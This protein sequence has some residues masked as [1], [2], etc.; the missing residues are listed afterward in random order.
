M[1]K[2]IEFEV[3]KDLKDIDT[4]IQIEELC[5]SGIPLSKEY[6]ELLLS[7]LSYMIRKKISDAEEINMIENT[8]TNK[9]DLAQSMTYYYLKELNVKVNPVN[10]NEV[11]EGVCGH[12]FVI[13]YFNTTVGEKLYLIDPTYLQFFFKEN[14]DINRFIIIKDKVCRTPDPGFFVVK[15][16][17]QD[18]ILP[19]LTEGYIE[20]REDVAK[21]FGDSFFQT[22]QGVHKNQIQYNVASGQSYIKWFE[23]YTSNLS[24]SEEELRAMDLL[25]SFY[26]LSKPKSK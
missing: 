14:C 4:I 12:S 2:I 9:C 17:K 15:N 23:R 3:N 22:K 18:T 13:A 21:V 20:F 25:I 8:Y 10:T 19:L 11:I 6:V 1:N 5:K 7:N 24:K 16:N 26:D